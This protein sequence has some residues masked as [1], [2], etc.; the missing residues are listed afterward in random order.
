MLPDGGFG[1][2]VVDAAHSHVFVSSDF[3]QSGDHVTV[4]DFDGRI[5]TTIGD[6]PHASGLAI[7][8]DTLFV[9]RCMVTAADGGSGVPPFPGT[10][11]DLISTTT[12]T[13]TASV[14]V[15]SGVIAPQIGLG[16][17][18]KPACP[19]AVAGGRVWFLTQDDSGASVTASIDAAPPYAFRTYPGMIA[20]TSFATTP[21][22]PDRL[23]VS[24]GQTAFYDVS[25]P[26]PV[27]LGSRGDHLGSPHI[28][29]DGS[30]VAADAN[31]GLHGYTLP[32]LAQ[33]GPLYASAPNPLL[34]V[35]VAPSG[36]HVAAALVAGGND[37]QVFRTGVPGPKLVVSTA[38]PDIFWTGKDG[39][40]YDPSGQKLFVV[41]YHPLGGPAVFRVIDRVDLIGTSLTV[42]APTVP[43]SSAAFVSGVLSAT[44]GSAVSGL[45]VHMSAS[46]P[47]GL[48]IVGDVVTD[49]AASM[50]GYAPGCRRGRD[51]G[52]LPPRG[53]ATTVCG[54]RPR[55]PR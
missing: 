24:G 41:K 34:A 3:N 36:D 50:S 35:A 4:L 39:L 49:S 25:Q 14:P 2:M 45:T 55:P 12:L 46:S 33:I 38:T 32:D 13:R 6:E 48:T 54:Q 11:I 44:D 5:I 42:V 8:G 37:V 20:A 40:A 18:P 22:A 1:A 7:S 15:A 51:R 26:D 30:T 29:S 23:L 43:V 17:V 21:A 10:A 47:S 31:G 53:A 52:P 16:Y 28:S 19:I 9:A 27:V